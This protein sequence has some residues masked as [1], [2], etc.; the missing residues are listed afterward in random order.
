MRA[1]SALVLLAVSALP[2]AAQ[3]PLVGQPLSGQS[4]FGQP[5]PAARAAAPV[6]P[7]G[8]FL[9]DVA[10]GVP[11]DLPVAAVGA[12]NGDLYVV[13]KAGVVRVVRAGA[14]LPQPF[15]DLRDE[16]H[17]GLDYGLLGF[18]LA[19]DFATSRHVVLSYVVA[20]GGRETNA[21]GSPRT[22][23][24][25]R[26][27]RYTASADG[28][29]A[30]PA[31][32][33]VLIGETWA[34]GIPACSGSHS[35]GTVQFGL[36]GALYVGAGDG[37]GFEG[38]DEGGEHP[39]CFQAGRLPASED[40]GAFRAQ[41][42]QSLAGK[43]LR[44][45]PATGLGLPDNPFWTGN[46]ADNASRVWVL[47]VRNPFRFTLG[48]GTGPATA[49]AAD[50][51]YFTWEEMNVA[52]G[53][54]NLG[55]PCY[56]GP[57]MLDGYWQAEPPTNG[58]PTVQTPQ[59]PVFWWNHDDPADSVPA[60][61]TG[62]SVLSGPV[63]AGTRYPQAMRGRLFSAD[64]ER[65]WIATAAVGPGGGLS[66]DAAFATDAGYIVH[67][68]YAPATQW[69]TL[70]DVASGTV[71]EL[72]HIDGEDNSAPVVQLGASPHQGSAPLEVTFSGSASFDP[73]GDAVTY[74]WVF[75]DG[76][77]ST[78]PDPV[79]V[80]TV[81]GSYTARLTV[82]DGAGASASA[83]TEILVSAGTAPTAEIT[84]P[85]EGTVISAIDLA[86][87]SATLALVG[88]GADADQAPETLAYAWDVTLLHNAHI[89][90]NA[91]SAS[92]PEASYT[93]EAHGSG[94]DYYAVRIRPHR[95]R[96][97]G[98]QRDRRARGAVRVRRRLA[99]ARLDGRDAGRAGRRGR[100]VP[101]RRRRVPRPR[102]GRPVGLRRRGR[103][104]HARARRRRL[105]HGA[106]RVGH[107][108]R[109]GRR[110]QGRRDAAPGPR[111][112]RAVRDDVPLARPGRRVPVAR[113]LGP[114]DA[115]RDPAARQPGVGVG[116]AG[117]QRRPGP[118]LLV[119]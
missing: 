97:R 59:A 82:A 79:H 9:V 117:A 80:Y 32:R 106:R 92:G 118:R 43:I 110:R 24:F 57:G 69:L 20:E 11:F 109:P 116:P 77:T 72:H 18:A 50:V 40:I 49:Y 76:A 60:G 5:L 45:D 48:T 100:L 78:L 94:G 103:G 71:W 13:E 34:T 112:A 14:V 99:A 29:A 70:T 30:L 10:G 65:G 73:D 102:L 6:L 52:A 42:L 107:R 93:V 111:P 104:R 16:V 114:G 7:E 1:L 28:S 88:V 47:G 2:A 105:G 87:G 44:L 53:G 91:F 51:G 46:A 85:V 37:A 81:P 74:A 35:I 64:Y 75:G 95:H 113:R 8:Y 55:W 63:Y 3:T 19:P 26:V 39:A 67:I 66:D 89:H 36:D 96:Q 62:A 56:E 31:S 101:H 68:G 12:P 23:A 86:G 4:L 22:D 115:G 84:S 27:T 90:P 33:Q 41:R 108:R 98:A 58:C 25:S 17:G 119:A 15:L 38:A 21:D 61:R 83:T 54:A